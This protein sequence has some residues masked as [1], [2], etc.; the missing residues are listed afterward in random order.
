MKTLA[1]SVELIARK[2]KVREAIDKL[3][4]ERADENENSGKDKVDVSLDKERSI[5]I[6]RV[7]AE[8]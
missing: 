6:R 4:R 5:T 8:A 1:R 7:R 2:A 3:L